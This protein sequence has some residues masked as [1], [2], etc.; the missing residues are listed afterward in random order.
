MSLSLCKVQPWADYNA[1][2]KNYRPVEHDHG[3]NK[4]KI[5]EDVRCMHLKTMKLWD[6]CFW[7]RLI[8][9]NSISVQ[10]LCGVEYWPFPERKVMVGTRLTAH[11][12]PC[13][14]SK[15]TW[16]CF[17]L[18][19]LVGQFYQWQLENETRTVTDFMRL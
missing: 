11:S 1:D 2:H 5:Q 9:A 15:S 18:G 14:L 4:L 12:V 16:S 8:L 7:L 3:N 19:N 6:L 10:L 17:N 13:S